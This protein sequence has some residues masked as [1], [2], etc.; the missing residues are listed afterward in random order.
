[1]SSGRAFD[2]DQLLA[3]FDRIGEAALANETVLEFAVYGGAALMLAS[4]FRFATE[5]ADIGELPSP[6]PDWLTGVIGDIAREND[7]SSDWLNED[8]QFHLSQIADHAVDHMEFSSFPAGGRPGLRVFVPTAEYMLALK[9]KASRIN[10]PAKGP[11]ETL[12]IQNLIRAAGIGDVEEAVAVLAKFF[13]KSGADAA[14]QR[15]LLRHIW[16]EESSDDAPE[17]PVLGR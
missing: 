8:V 13:P 2:R 11:Q 6:W 1:M 3:A 5:D 4:R 9:L 12:D 14:K 10:D 7:W 15:F 16:P 17:Y